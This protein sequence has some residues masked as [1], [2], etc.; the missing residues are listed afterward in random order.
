MSTAF[1]MSCFMEAETSRHKRVA[2]KFIDNKLVKSAPGLPKWCHND[3][4]IYSRPFVHVVENQELSTLKSSL[5]GTL[6]DS[7]I[8]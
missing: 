3:K 5:L 2:L 7:N 1:T 4:F 8:Y 6:R